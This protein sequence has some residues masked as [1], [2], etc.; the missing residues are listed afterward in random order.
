MTRSGVARMIEHNGKTQ[1]VSDWAREIGVSR[2][3]LCTRLNAL[4]WPVARALSAQSHIA[5]SGVAYGAGYVKAGYLVKSADGV[6]RAEHIV[7]AERALGR[8]LPAG[9]VVHHV[10]ENPLNNEPGNLVICPSQAYHMTLHRRMRA[11]AACGH[12]GWRKC[13]YCKTYSDPST[14]RV[15][16]AGA[17]HQACANAYS[18]ATYHPK[19]K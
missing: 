11:L 19:E 3:L 16:S 14:M 9:A 12:A 10:D 13:K 7:V 15:T 4:G 8:P 17:F 5:P 18:R 2:K 6:Q 1:S